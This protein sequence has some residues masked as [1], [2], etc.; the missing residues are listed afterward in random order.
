MHIQ[1]TSS[2]QG[3]ADYK[4]DIIASLEQQPCRQMRGSMPLLPVQGGV[5]SPFVYE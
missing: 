1:Q 4:N 3:C 5:G 2:L